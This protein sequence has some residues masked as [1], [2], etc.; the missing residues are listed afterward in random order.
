MEHRLQRHRPTQPARGP[1]GARQRTVESRVGD[2]DDEQTAGGQDAVRLADG[3][4]RV[5]REVH[6][7]EE[8][9]RVDA[10]V[11][12]GQRGAVGLHRD[13]GDAGEGHGARLV[14]Q[15]AA[16]TAPPEPR[17]F[18][19]EMSAAAADVEQPTRPMQPREGGRDRPEEPPTGLGGSRVVEGARILHVVEMPDARPRR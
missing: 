8:R 1:E 9:D 10:S 6:D 13:A 3:G 14:G 12:H 7:P 4:E 16:D 19:Q 17:G 15:I 2:A 18:G 5:G 11:P